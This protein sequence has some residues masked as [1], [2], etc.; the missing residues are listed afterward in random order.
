VRDAVDNQRQLV[1]FNDSA[2]PATYTRV[3][4]ADRDELRRLVDDLP[5]AQVP[6]ALEDVRRHLAST[7]GFGAWPPPWFGSAS[8]SRSDVAG[9]S[10]ELL[11]DGFGRDQ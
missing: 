6:A 11:A 8:A 5:D 4:S 9:R 7:D 3:V 1:G 10:E 2:A